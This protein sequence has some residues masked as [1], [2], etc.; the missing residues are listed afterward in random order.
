MGA[1]LGRALPGEVVA[2][3]DADAIAAQW[4]SAIEEPPSARHKVLVALDGEIVVGFAA[5][6]P[7]EAD[8]GESGRGELGGAWIDAEIV[9]LEVDPGY[10][11]DTHAARL[12]NA[13]ADILAMAGA[14]SMR[15]WAVRGDELRQRFLTDSDFAPL[16]L[17]RAYEVAGAEMIEDAWWAGIG[18][19]ATAE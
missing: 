14:E 12:L 18:D 11:G 13:T 19:P 7:L 6:A 15:I 1:G 10:P 3:F 5:I 2:L 4:R 16:G 9:A 8:G 17:R